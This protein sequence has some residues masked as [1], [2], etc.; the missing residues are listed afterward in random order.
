ML[1]G[2]C[3]VGCP[4]AGKSGDTAPRPGESEILEK[5]VGPKTAS[6][7]CVCKCAGDFLP[8][9]DTTDVLKCRSFQNQACINLEGDKEGTTEDCQI[10]WVYPTKPDADDNLVVDPDPPA[11]SP[12]DED[13]TQ[14]TAPVQPGATPSP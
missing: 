5:E 13:P 11:I 4:A 10:R 1:I 8:M 2:S 6:Q 3:L 14:P 9:A 7:M 12:A